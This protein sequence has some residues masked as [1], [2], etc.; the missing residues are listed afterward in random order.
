MSDAPGRPLLQYSG[1]LAISVMSI[2]MLLAT[3]MRWL[4]SIL[5]GLDKGYHLHK[6]LGIT[7]FCAALFHWLQSE[8]PELFGGGD[9]EGEDDD[10]E[11]GDGEEGSFDFSEIDFSSPEAF[12]ESFESPAHTFGELAFYAI[13]LLILIALIKSIPYRFFAKTHQ[14]IPVAY[15][16]LVFHGI[17]LMKFEYWLTLTGAV[18]GGL[19][20]TGVVS[21][22]FILSRFKGRSLKTKGTVTGVLEY[23]EMQALEITITPE[24]NWQGHQSGQFAFLSL[25]N[26]KEPHPFTISSAWDE[27][28]PKI[29]FTIKSLGHYT[30]RIRNNINVGD[31]IT[32][33]GPYGRFNFADQSQRQIWVAGGIGI[34][35]FL[36]RLEFLS[37]NKNTQPVDLFFL[38]REV[39]PELIERIQALSGKAGVTFHNFANGAGGRF[40]CNRLRNLI[41]DWKES[42]VWFCGPVGLGNMLYKDMSG[43]GLQKTKFHREVFEMR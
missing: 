10:D 13:M 18:T 37:K 26:S 16:A 38:A 1:I 36:S 8:F 27:G 33:E 43:N 9:G 2:A 28:A 20:F 4:E 19:M 14:I 6:W 21:A 39:D 31:V 17:V 24:E 42:S 3:R 29:T 35:P 15:L 22:I 34:T 32:V 7:A 12:L 11:E 5:G 23:S 41:P 40:E 25:P 30:R